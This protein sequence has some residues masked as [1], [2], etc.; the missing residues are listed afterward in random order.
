MQK[1][2]YIS[3]GCVKERFFSAMLATIALW[4][5]EERILFY[6][7]LFFFS[8]C[9]WNRWN[10]R[11]YSRHLNSN[12]LDHAMQLAYFFFPSWNKIF[13]YKLVIILCDKIIFELLMQ[14][15]K[16]TINCI[17][18]T[19]TIHT[20]G[21]VHFIS[22]MLRCNSKLVDARKDCLVQWTRLFHPFRAP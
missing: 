10:S 1:S 16:Y 20:Y 8:S 4:T 11:R 12:K 9:I 13:L 22:Y 7:L 17:F 14:S 18:K 5:N 15:D 21:K 3:A 2:M 19:N 6:T